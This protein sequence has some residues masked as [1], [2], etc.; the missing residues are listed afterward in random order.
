MKILVLA[1][2]V[3]AFDPA[4][5][6]AEDCACAAGG[7]EPDTHEYCPCEDPIEISAIIK[8]TCNNE[9][10][11]CCKTNFVVRNDGVNPPKNPSGPGEIDCKHGKHFDVMFG[12]TLQPKND[13]PT[14]G[15]FSKSSSEGSGGGGYNAVR[16]VSAKGSA[17]AAEDFRRG[18]P[19]WRVGLGQDSS[20]NPSG[21]ICI[22]PKGL[23]SDPLS[24][25]VLDIAVA[26]GKIDVWYHTDWLTNVVVSATNES[27][28]VTNVE[29]VVDSSFPEQILAKECF[30]TV[31]TNAEPSLAVR[32]YH[33]DQVELELTEVGAYALMEGAEP[34]VEYLVTRPEASERVFRTRIA[35]RRSGQVVSVVDFA[36]ET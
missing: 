6:H 8:T 35:E 33:P 19:M 22:K 17:R 2:G 23:Y 9:Q 31:S 5:L 18:T 4:A 32:F 27:V 16:A 11:G 25:A 36:K 12:V 34:Y 30:V 28:I 3:I 24:P 7:T 21:Q 29:A 14:A 15:D 20:G 13:S 26:N 10:T 1:L